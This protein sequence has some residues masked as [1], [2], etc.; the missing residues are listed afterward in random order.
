[1]SEFTWLRIVIVSMCR[2]LEYIIFKYMI[3]INSEYSLSKKEWILFIAMPLLTWFAVT[4]MTQSTL[5]KHSVEPQMFYIALIMIAID[6]IIFFFMH[7]IKQDT[8]LR[9]EYEMLQMHYDNVQNTE[10][11]MK[12]L[13]ENTYSVKHDLEKH[14]LAIKAM[15]ESS[16][17]DDIKEYVSKIVDK[18]LNDVQKIVFTDNDVFN[19]IINTKLEI[20]KQKNIYPTINISNEAVRYI[21]NSDIAVLFGNLFDNAIEAAEKTDEKII[22][23]SIKMQNEYVSVYMENSYNKQ[24]SDIELK[25]TKENKTE[26]GFGTRIVKKLVRENG[27]MIE[28]FENSYGLFCCDILL[29]RF[30]KNI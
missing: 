6:V 22:A 17:C 13:Y 26:H 4:L 19:A 10:R 30:E 23:F 20:C 1:M 24:H 11:N 18:K 14:M 9:H 16:N 3:S 21:N 8:K 28:F 2:I 25:T 12:A 5:D 27:G 29:R 7:K 15:A